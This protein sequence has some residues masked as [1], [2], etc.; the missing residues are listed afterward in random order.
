MSPQTQRMLIGA[1]IGFMFLV[2]LYVSWQAFLMA[3]VADTPQ[4]TTLGRESPATSG[5]STLD[6]LIENEQAAIQLAENA[7]MERLALARASLLSLSQLGEEILQTLDQ[8]Q[9]ELK[10][11]EEE[12][13]PLLTNDRGKRLA[14]NPELVK[15]FNAI[16][17]ARKTSPAEL[18]KDRT[19]VQALLLP[20]ENQLKS[21]GDISAPTE[22]IAAELQEEKTLSQTKLNACRTAR[23][24]LE[25][26]LAQAERAGQTSPKT[27]HAAI[28]ELKISYALEQA[29]I[30]NETEDATQKQIAQL[31]AEA[32]RQ[33][34]EQAG[35]DEVQRIEA[36]TRKKQAEAEAERARID[37][38]TAKIQ[39][40]IEARQ[41]LTQA[42]SERAKEAARRE[43]LRKLAEDSNV[44][45]KFLPFLEKGIFNFGS[46]SPKNRYEF[47]KP[48]S[49]TD[50]QKIGALEDGRSFAAV[51][52]GK[53]TEKFAYASSNDRPKWNYPTAEEE[54]K[55][56]EALLIQFKDLA[57]I[58]VE[59][60][61]LQP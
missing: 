49:L 22:G 29:R 5:Q 58:W 54:F 12:I 47:A 41:Q 9:N 18:E 57:P 27:L 45:K 16:Y 31:I 23:E 6:V 42:E 24:G 34:L 46:P 21:A 30:I 61:L 32:R 56:Y 3:W 36:E 44:Q 37:A 55:Q 43:K 50:L 10:R 11:W 19:R 8:V 20:V 7:K 2:V 15:A 4:Q 33:Q 28:E 51:G 53:K 59:M 60:G 13:E 40:D 26:F 35:K 38:E 14:A 25:S 17:A 39:S 52:A 1:G 48:V